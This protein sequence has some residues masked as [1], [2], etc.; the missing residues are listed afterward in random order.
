M[1][2]QPVGEPTSARRYLLSVTSFGFLAGIIRRPEPTG[3][4]ASQCRNGD[5]PARLVRRRAILYFHLN[6]QLRDEGGEQRQRKPT[7]RRSPSGQMR[8]S[9]VRGLLNGDRRSDD[10]RLPDPEPLFTCRECGH[11]GMADSQMTDH[12]PDLPRYLIRIGLRGWMV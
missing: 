2:T 7:D 10:V 3:F 12:P 8:F 5:E 11:R 1:R 9:G 6:G 4:L